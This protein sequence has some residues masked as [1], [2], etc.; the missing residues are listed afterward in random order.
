MMVALLAS[1]TLSGRSDT[2]LA[3]HSGGRLEVSNFSGMVFVTTWNRDAVRIRAQGEGATEVEVSPQSGGLEINTSGRRVVP[4][5][6]DLNITA[7]TWIPIE[8]S[9]PMNDVQIDGTKASVK[10]ETV[11]GGVTLRG[12]SG[13]VELSSVQGQVEVTGASGHLKLSAINRGVTASHISGQAEIETVNG[14]IL[15]DDVQLDELDASSVSG[16]LWLSGAL[17]PDGRYQLQ[18]HAG[19]V[20]VV[21]PDKPSVRVTVSTYS[22]ELSSD[23]EFGLSRMGGREKEDVNFTLGEGGSRLDLES[24]SGRIQLLK[25][26]E[27]DAL[28]KSLKTVRPEK[29]KEPKGKSKSGDSDQ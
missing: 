8:V 9:G 17:R 4:G 27:V 5:R 12:G 23:F 28:R 3:V 29:G 13:D 15:L 21:L 6:V 7:P 10:V 25:A 2:T 11:N 16:N 18:S 22:G 14:D 20:Q 24:F 1:I 19:D 26:S